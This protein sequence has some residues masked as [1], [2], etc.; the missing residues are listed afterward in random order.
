MEEIAF[1]L[2][3]YVED[4]LIFELGVVPHILFGSDEVK[5]ALLSGHVNTDLQRAKKY[6]VPSNF[7][8]ILDDQEVNGLT[9]ERYRVMAHSGT[10]TILFEEIFKDHTNS[11]APLLCITPVFNGVLSFTGQETIHC[12]PEAYPA[13]IHE[14]PFPH[15]LD[16]YLTED[17]FRLA[18]LINDDFFVAIRATFNLKLY[19]SSIKLM[20][21]FIDTIAYLEY[22]DT[23]GNFQKW[24]TTFT[25]LSPLGINAEELWEFRNS[26][27]HMT[28]LD[29][30]KVLNG[31]VM[32]VQFYVAIDSMGHFVKSDEAKYFNYWQLI[33]TI[34][35]AVEN[36]YVT[37]DADRG[38]IALFADRYERIISDKRYAFIRIKKP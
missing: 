7:R 3:L 16:E 20:M 22:G 18:D 35:R 6:K 17:G 9:Y 29:S 36:W 25:D 38:K 24:L 4:D 26:I 27:L 23:Q 2:F 11:I 12:L 14:V 8:I 32:R 28:N 31:K 37:F 30:R 15:F 34:A 21:S 33:G 5:L 19:A 13:S 1:N 10:D